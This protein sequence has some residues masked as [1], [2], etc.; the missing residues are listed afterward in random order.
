VLEGDVPN[1][2]DPP[3]GCAFRTRCR[4]ALPECA[5][6][7]PGLRMVGPGH[8]TACIRDDILRRAPEED[9]RVQASEH[10]EPTSAA[11]A[12]SPSARRSR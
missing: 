11:E 6:E 5:G 4:Y 9:D 7:R 2:I 10:P 8:Y 3:S 1:S 12:Y